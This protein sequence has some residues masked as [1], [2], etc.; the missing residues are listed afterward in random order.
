MPW[1]YSGRS[2]F[3]SSTVTHSYFSRGL[4]TK[5]L[6]LDASMMNA[7]VYHCTRHSF[8][9]MSRSGMV[10]T[11]S[12]ILSLRFTTIVFISLSETFGWWCARDRSFP[13]NNPTVRKSC[14][15][16]SLRVS[17]VCDTDGVKLF[18]K[19]YGV[20][21]PFFYESLI[22]SSWNTVNCLSNCLFCNS[23]IAINSE[24]HLY[25]VQFDFLL[26]QVWIFAIVWFLL[27]VISYFWWNQSKKWVHFLILLWILCSHSHSI[28]FETNTETYENSSY[29]VESYLRK[30]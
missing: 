3:E 22:C 2:I 29:S 4:R 21:I 30:K 19:I 13:R 15:M 20:L 26:I 18:N 6:S 25:F 17:L 28:K 1:T 8:I 27:I 10:S 9:N 24:F 12:P 23:Q 7:P 16:R 11:A 14:R 5:R